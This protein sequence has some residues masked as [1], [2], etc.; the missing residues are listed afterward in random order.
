MDPA[1]A[2]HVQ[3][4]QGYLSLN[5][6]ESDT[7]AYLIDPILR[8]LG[9]KDV[10]DLRREVPIP[11]TKE[12]L[13]YELLI[14]GQPVAIVE[15]KALRHHLNDQHA[16]QCVQY[17]S[18]LGI[19]WCL[20]TNGIEWALYDAHGKGPLADKR[21]VGVRLDGPEAD[22]QEAWAVLSLFSPDAFTQAN[23]LARLLIERVVADDLARPDS[24]AVEALRRSARSRFGERI[25]GQTVVSTVHQLMNRTRG[26]K[27]N[28]GSE[29][30][31]NGPDRPHEEPSKIAAPV[32]ALPTRSER[33]FRAW[34]TRRGDQPPSPSREHQRR[35][36][37]ADLIT[38]GL[39]P[40]D[41]ALEVRIR[42][43][44]YVG[45]LREGQIEVGGQ[46][47]STP[48]SASIALRD[49]PSWNGWTDWLYK[50]ETLAHIRQRYGDSRK[51][52]DAAAPD[53]DRRPGGR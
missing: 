4:L 18:I 44:S 46:L 33:A 36:T 48:S 27:P 26:I 50:G 24:P 16:A 10:T 13:D 14:R 41:A 23:P 30:L 17:A 42:G 2:G 7:R 1:F 45:R 51:A 29:L 53:T 39:L 9:Y 38:A 40:D 25:S 5:L 28:G 12:T 15:A 21:I 11:A 3:Q 43:A 52:S 49:V 6:S 22:T 34:A 19:R 47:F 31:S 35:I 32:P 20:I 8:I 37:L